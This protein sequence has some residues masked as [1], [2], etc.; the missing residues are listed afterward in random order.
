MNGGFA[1]YCNLT[2]AQRAASRA[3]YDDLLDAA[4]EALGAGFWP[5]DVHEVIFKPA[6]DRG[7]YVWPVLRDELIAHARRITPRTS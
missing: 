5:D 4:C 3:A 7:L 6:R 1:Y 2:G